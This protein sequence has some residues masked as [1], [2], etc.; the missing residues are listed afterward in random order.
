MTKVRDLHKNW[1]KAP[2]Y[3]TAYDALEAEFA[4][5]R[6]VLR[7]RLAAGLTQEDLARRMRTTQSAIAR[8]ESGRVRPSTRT[9]ERLAQ[10]TGTRLRIVFEKVQDRPR[11]RA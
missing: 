11:R 8:L 10:A 4:T 5:A 2:K 3:R 6:A 7:A 9:L 1:M